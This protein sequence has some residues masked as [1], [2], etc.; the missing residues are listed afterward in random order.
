[1]NYISQVIRMH[2][3]P[4]CHCR[5]QGHKGIASCIL[6][7]GKHQQKKIISGLCQFLYIFQN[8]LNTLL[9]TDIEES[10]LIQKSLSC[11]SLLRLVSTHGLPDLA[12]QF[13][14]SMKTILSKASKCCGTGDNCHRQ[15][16]LQLSFP[17][18]MCLSQR[19]TRSTNMGTAIE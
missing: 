2:V 7:T 15:T 16:Q 1:M 8:Y 4:F 9:P 6:M 3:Y 5:E 13:I 10:F 18:K 19:S 14:S 12:S 17:I 11:V